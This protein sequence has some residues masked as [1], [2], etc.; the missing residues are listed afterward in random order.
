[1]Q[2]DERLPFLAGKPVNEMSL[3]EIAEQLEKVTSW[4]EAQRVKEREARAAYT[5]V[6]QQVESSVSQIRQYAQQLVDAQ[7]RKVSSFSGMLNK[8]QGRNNVG[9]RRV[10]NGGSGGA[11][12]GRPTAGKMNIADA[13][14]AIWSLD[15]YQEQLTTE[16]IGDALPETGYRSNAAPTSLKSS[17]NQALAKLCR[18]GQVIRFRSDGSRISAR[19]NKSRA[20]KY[21]AANL[22]GDE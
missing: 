5:A 21:I 18:S 1:M 20:R 14:L 8:D 12:A 6:A 10:G 15:R 13:I 22:A 2:P 9:Q 7:N 3:V 17:I 4:I 19:D 11:G 16:E